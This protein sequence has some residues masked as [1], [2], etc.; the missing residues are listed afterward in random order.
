MIKWF[1]DE[2]GKEIP[3]IHVSAITVNGQELHGDIHI[4]CLGAF[5]KRKTKLSA[6]RGMRVDP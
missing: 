4:E 5:I 6:L 1:C 3:G 2:C